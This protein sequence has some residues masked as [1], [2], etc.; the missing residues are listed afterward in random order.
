MRGGNSSSYEV[1]K[2]R[3]TRWFLLGLLSIT[4]CFN[5]IFLF[6]T[7]LPI[8][9]IKRYIYVKRPCTLVADNAPVTT[10][11]DHHLSHD[12]LSTQA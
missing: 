2:T 12:K 3:H 4:Y 5:S 6:S 8:C 10:A 7:A 11:F 9:L 1:W